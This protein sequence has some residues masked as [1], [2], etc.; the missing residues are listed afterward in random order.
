MH[1]TRVIA[2]VTGCLLLVS[3]AGAA[4][5]SRASPYSLLL[6]A[7]AGTLN[8][9]DPF[10]VTMAFGATVGRYRGTHSMAL[11]ILMQSQ[12]RNSGPSL[13]RDARTFLLLTWEKGRAWHGQPARQVFFRLGGGVVLRSPY[14]A[15]PALDLA[16]G[17]KYRMR[18]HLLL[19]GSVGDLIAFL[20]RDTYS[21]CRG[22]GTQGC[23]TGGKAQ[24]NFGLTIAVE[25][26]P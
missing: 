4:Q 13:T 14:R 15:G 2:A 3:S 1:G 8:P 25:L 21:N 5:A 24:S 17:W 26:H 23:A 12:N 22:P 19:V 18:Q 20:P 7:E 9:D 16:V 6:R 11:R 10:A